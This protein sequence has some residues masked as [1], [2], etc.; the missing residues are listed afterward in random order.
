MKTRGNEVKLTI[1]MVTSGLVLMAVLISQ[2]KELALVVTAL[3]AVA[4]LWGDHLY[5][6]YSTTVED[7]FDAGLDPYPKLRWYTV[8]VLFLLQLAFV[9]AVVGTPFNKYGM[10][11]LI[12]PI[13]YVVGVV[14]MVLDDLGIISLVQDEASKL[15]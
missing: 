3:F 2:A 4:S 15:K 9:L 6:K 1:V 13:C 7:V 5:N 11:L 8:V 14:M 10:M 12:F